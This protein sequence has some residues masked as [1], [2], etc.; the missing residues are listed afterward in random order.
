MGAVVSTSVGA[1]MS[2]TGGSLLRISGIRIWC[3]LQLRTSIVNA[4]KGFGFQ[5]S[6]SRAATQN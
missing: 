5:C 4:D 6:E 3:A 1:V 2:S